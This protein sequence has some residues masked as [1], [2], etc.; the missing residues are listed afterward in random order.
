VQDA[1]DTSNIQPT[2]LFFQPRPTRDN[3]KQANIDN[4]VAQPEMKDAP[5][6]GYWYLHQRSA[7]SDVAFEL[8]SPSYPKSS[9]D[10]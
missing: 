7:E 4:G 2:A 6:Y 5:V 9:G 8:Y 3:S 1:V 10:Q